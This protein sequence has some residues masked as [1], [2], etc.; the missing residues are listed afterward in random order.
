MDDT[1]GTVGGT[2]TQWVQD[3]GPLGAND[4]Q[5]TTQWTTQMARWK[6]QWTTQW[7]QDVGPLGA[8]GLR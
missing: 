3:T 4:L 5:W 7:V 1:N 2:T 8:V 6:A